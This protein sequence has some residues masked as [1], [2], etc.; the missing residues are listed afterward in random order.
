[1]LIREGA[2]RT[3]DPIAVASRSMDGELLDGGDVGYS[4]VAVL[5]PGA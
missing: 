1:M 3:M 4:S 2:L 5:D